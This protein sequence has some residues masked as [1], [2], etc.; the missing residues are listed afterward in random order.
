MVGRARKAV[1]ITAGLNAKETPVHRVLL[2]RK[3]SD[4]G[5]DCRRRIPRLPADGMT[6]LESSTLRENRDRVRIAEA[7]IE[8]C[9]TCSSCDTECPVNAATGLLRPQQIVR[10][11]A[12]GLLDELLNAP[13]IWYCISCRRCSQICP[14]RVKPSLLINYLRQKAIGR[15]LVSWQSYERY[16]DWIIDFQHIRW[17]AI[18][19]GLNRA[20]VS[21]DNMTDSLVERTV[22]IPKSKNT[23][24]PSPLESLAVEAQEIQASGCYSC[25]ECSSACPIVSGRNVF[26]PAVIVHM[27]N[28][29][30]EDELLASPS[31]WMCLQ[32]HR[33]TDACP[34][35]VK[36]HRLF[37]LLRMQSIEQKNESATFQYQLEEIHRKLYP[38]WVKTV[39]TIIQ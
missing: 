3:S 26:D 19:R 38:L 29:G 31:I 21:I 6:V 8:P 32:C 2:A 24:I 10:M 27:L 37:Q 5:L 36:G 13:E 4:S 25:R 33:C 16:Q 14:N 17:K 1:T 12:F 7:D 20:K 35:N 39:D 28:L 23:I 22:E 34:Q 9:W 30:M 15:G 18:A 11:A